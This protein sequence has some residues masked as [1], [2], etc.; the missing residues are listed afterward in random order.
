MSLTPE[1]LHITVSD[2][3]SVVAR[4]QQWD[5]P[6]TAQSFG[7][8]L[9]AHHRGSAFVGATVRHVAPFTMRDAN[10]IFNRMAEDDAE[11]K[12]NFPVRGGLLSLCDKTM[13]LSLK[14]DLDG[15]IAP[16]ASLWNIRPKK[17]IVPHGCKYAVLVGV[18]LKYRPLTPL[19][20]KVGRVEVELVDEGLA[21]GETP[22]MVSFSK[23]LS[24]H[25]LMGLSHP[26][27][28]DRLSRIK[29]KVTASS[30]GVAAGE[31]WGTMEMCFRFH[32]SSKPLV[33]AMTPSVVQYE[34]PS[35]IFEVRSKDPRVFHAELEQDD[36][37]TLRDISADIQDVD[38]SRLVNVGTFISKVTGS[39]GMSGQR[40]APVPAPSEGW[41]NTDPFSQNTLAA[42]VA[43]G[44]IPRPNTA[45]IE[46]A[47]A[48]LNEMRE[49]HKK[50][51]KPR[52]ATIS[53][54]DTGSSTSPVEASMPVNNPFLTPDVSVQDGRS[55]VSFN[56]SSPA[57]MTGPVVSGLY[58]VIKL[59]LGIEIQ[60][61]ITRPSDIHDP[62]VALAIAGARGSTIV[63]IHIDAEFQRGRIS[64]HNF[65][66]AN[67]ASLALVFNL[68]PG[69]DFHTL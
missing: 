17:T 39:T 2:T 8:Q 14:R 36:I 37:D 53:A 22:P 6:E 52:L 19:F 33:L 21:V 63:Y 57:G 1:Q 45:S 50:A 13:T 20:A 62:A 34:L 18:L 64:T 60:G 61:D 25:V 16:K 56:P 69:I 55:G 42:R 15:G 10:S 35:D 32:F 24:A 51:P 67:A 68:F 12:S 47:Q 58:A 44:E 54:S 30:T 48:R 4:A 3:N 49:F 29:L 59:V 65:A 11:E 23:N 7:D 43:R 40:V 27:G 41:L 31:A 28:V 5:F 66:T 9:A 26:I 46:E 38:R